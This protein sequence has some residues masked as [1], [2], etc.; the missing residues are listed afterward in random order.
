[1][2]TLPN[3]RIEYYENENYYVIQEQVL[4]YAN[5]I[6]EALGTYPVAGVFDLL[7]QMQGFSLAVLSIGLIFNILIIMF[8]TISVLLIYSLLMITT[9]TK[10][11]DYGV[12]RLVGLNSCGFVSMIL[13][14]GIMFVIPSIVC[15]FACSLPSLKY[16]WY[17]M[18]QGDADYSVSIIP[19]TKASVL[20]LVIGLLI[21]TIS[22]VI[23][24][25]RALSKSL[26]DAL[27]VARLQ[28]SGTVIS[29]TGGDK[30]KVLPYAAFGS[31]CVLSG[32]AIYILLP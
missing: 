3:P 18:F 28:T 2:M 32:A 23:P 17:K 11:F 27:N 21:P 22:A 24:I 9:E 8:V 16:L 20:G 31:L 19:S 4:G 10:T 15:A 14:Q 5:E 13:I 30:A 26:N 25:T 29:I 12:M 6:I 1:M 7:V